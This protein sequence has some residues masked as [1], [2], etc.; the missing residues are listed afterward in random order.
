M[1]INTQEFRSSGR[2]YEP[3]SHSLSRAIV[4][5]ADTIDLQTA[6]IAEAKGQIEHLDRAAARAAKGE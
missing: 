2:A 1:T 5:A 6:E 4:E 3:V